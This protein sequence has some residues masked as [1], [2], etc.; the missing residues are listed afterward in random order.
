MLD[1]YKILNESNAARNIPTPSQLA[2]TYAG[3]TLYKNQ[4]E[5]N[6]IKLGNLVAKYP[7]VGTGPGTTEEGKMPEKAGTFRNR[8]A[9][10]L[11]MWANNSIANLPTSIPDPYN[12]AIDDYVTGMNKRNG[13]FTDF[14]MLTNG[15]LVGD[16][17]SVSTARDRAPALLEPGEFVLRKQ[18][19]DAL[20]INNAMRL[21][22]TGD[23]GSDPNIEVNIVNNGTPVNPVDTPTIRKENGKLI[24]DIVLDDLRNNGPIKRQIKSIR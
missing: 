19:V 1:T 5:Q 7:N 6:A 18:A 21:N 10:T 3:I 20:G 24:V 2:Y 12:K 9:Q 15:G 22:A 16:D 17:L 23:A 13:N 14:Y 4:L 11:A 8:P